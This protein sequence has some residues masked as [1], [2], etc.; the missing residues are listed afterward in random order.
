MDEVLGAIADAVSQLVIAFADSEEKNT[1]FGDMVPP[2]EVIQGA[3]KVR[4]A[5]CFLAV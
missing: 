4:Y 3:V 1:L 2:A 5:I